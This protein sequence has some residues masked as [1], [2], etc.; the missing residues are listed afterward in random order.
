[1]EY[2]YQDE[3]GEHEQCISES[4]LREALKINPFL[5]M[6]AGLKVI[7]DSESENV[8]TVICTRIGENNALDHYGIA[9]HEENCFSCGHPV[10]VGD[11]SPRQVPK[12]CGQCALK[13]GRIPDEFI[14]Q[15]KRANP[16]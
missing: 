11:I 9:W 13:E 7:P 1:M 16:E 2:K 5:K 6:P 15:F 4:T 10:I 12:M 14:E 8:T 3:A